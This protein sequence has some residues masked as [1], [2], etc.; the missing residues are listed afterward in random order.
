M[1]RAREAE[2]ATREAPLPVRSSGCASVIIATKLSRRLWIH[3]PV[4]CPPQLLARPSAST[5]DGSVKS[6]RA[7]THE[8][9]AQSQSAA[10]GSCSEQCSRALRS[11]L[12]RR[13]RTAAL[14][15]DHQ[16]CSSLERRCLLQ[17]PGALHCPAVH[18]AFAWLGVERSPA[19]A[20]AMAKHLRFMVAASAGCVPMPIF[21][22]QALLAT[23]TTACLKPAAPQV[24]VR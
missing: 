21:T 6:N 4:S 9:Y 5:T 24:R 3:G 18:S 11:V 14:A 16:S 19:Q 13:R 17:R 10:R 7:Q 2:L 12:C 22:L 1:S 20:R 8:K 15:A 23:A